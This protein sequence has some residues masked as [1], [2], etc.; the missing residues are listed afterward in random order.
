MEPFVVAVNASGE[1]PFSRP[2]PKL[3]MLI[4]LGCDDSPV[5]FDAGT[6]TVRCCAALRMG[7]LKRFGG[8]ASAGLLMPELCMSEFRTARAGFGLV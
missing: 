7:S 3:E 8:G 1:V 4:G 2:P 6:G 5:V